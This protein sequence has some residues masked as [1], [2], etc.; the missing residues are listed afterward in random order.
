MRLGR[1]KELDE[2]LE[3]NKTID[4]VAKSIENN[5]N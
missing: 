1:D 5:S 3:R 2:I 4:V